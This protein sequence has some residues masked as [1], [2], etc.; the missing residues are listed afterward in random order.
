MGVEIYGVAG[1]PPCRGVYL[2]AKAIGLDYTFH[3]V[4]MNA[5]EHKS[6]DFLK[7]NPAHTVPTLKDGDLCLGER[8]VSGKDRHRNDWTS[9][10]QIQLVLK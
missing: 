1:S 10:L 9:E 3:K 6:P 2:A 4:D 8:C 7:M 5:G